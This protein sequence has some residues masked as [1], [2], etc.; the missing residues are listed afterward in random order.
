MYRSFIQEVEDMDKDVGRT[1]AEGSEETDSQSDQI[2]LTVLF[3]S[4][5]LEY[6]IA[7]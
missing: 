3:S 7:S 1:Y 5:Q 4:L 2:C 6:G